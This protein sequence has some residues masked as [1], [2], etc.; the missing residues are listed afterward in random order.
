MRSFASAFRTAL[1]RA[2]GYECAFA[3]AFLGADSL[4]HALANVVA[5]ASAFHGTY[6]G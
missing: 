5:H 4:P 2:N 1:A 6:F 3:L